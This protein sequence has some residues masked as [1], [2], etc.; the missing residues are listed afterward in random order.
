MTGETTGSDIPNKPPSMKV[1]IGLVFFLLATGNPRLQE[2]GHNIILENAWLGGNTLAGFLTPVSMALIMGI[3]G[4][5]ACLALTILM[6]NWLE[7]RRAKETSGF[8]ILGVFFALFG[9]AVLPLMARSIIVDNATT[10]VKNVLTAEKEQGFS[11]AIRAEAERAT[12]DYS[13][14]V[15]NEALLVDLQRASANPKDIMTTLA[16]IDLLGAD[17]PASRFVVENGL[18]RPKD[19]Q[20]LQV[21][22]LSRVRNG[23]PA[24]SIALV[25]LSSSGAAGSP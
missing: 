20:A 23:D 6:G 4:T 7:K 2:F 25:G 17:H 24:A 5:I 16:A 10:A 18:V 11:P 9:A 15:E 1:F 3:G 8:V 13:S 14:V 22:L 19:I 21:A 12:R